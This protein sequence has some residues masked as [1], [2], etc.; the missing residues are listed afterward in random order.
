MAYERLSGDFAFVE[1]IATDDVVKLRT[2]VTR[3]LNKYQ[4]DLDTQCE[5]EFVQFQNF[6][7]HSDMNCDKTPENIL[8]YIKRHPLLESSFPNVTVALRIYLTLPVT[9]CE[10]E[11]SFSKLSLIKNARRTTMD[12]DRLNALAILSIEHDITRNLSFAHVIEKFSS[13]KAR[14]KTF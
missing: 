13:A 2:D 7:S 12:Q 10:A 1:S 4:I 5:E 3:L 8:T 6:I 11:R 9:V 14:K